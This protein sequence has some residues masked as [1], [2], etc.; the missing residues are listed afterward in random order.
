M[1]KHKDHKD[2]VAA[3]NKLLLGTS[4]ATAA[5]AGGKNAKSSRTSCFRLLL[6]L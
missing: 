3:A 2:K 4:S 1:A 5:V 6:G